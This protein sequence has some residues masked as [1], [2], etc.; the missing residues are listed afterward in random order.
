M[1]KAISLV[2]GSIDTRG[3]W[4]E[5]VFTQERRGSVRVRVGENRHAPQ[6]RV[7]ESAEH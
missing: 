7:T 3:G 6:R 1:E 5:H 2:L 4:L